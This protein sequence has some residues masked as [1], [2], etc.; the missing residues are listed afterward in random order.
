MRWNREEYLSHMTFQGSPREMFTEIFGLMVGVDK[1][2]K[3]QGATP[4][5]ISLKAFGWDYVPFTGTGVH[6]GARTGMKPRIISDTPEETISIDEMGRTMRLIKSSATIPLPLDHPVKGPED[7][8]RIRHWYEFDEDRIDMEYVRSLKKLQDQ[9]VV[10]LAGIP[11]GF[12]EPRQLL[13]E[14]GLCYAFYDEPEMIHDMLDTMANTCLKCYERVADYVQIDMLGVHEDMAGRSGPLIG[15]NLIEEFISPYYRKVWEPLKAQG[16][17]LFS[18]DSDGNMTA[19]I[20]AFLDAG[21]NCMYP[22]E[23]QAGMDVR[24]L[25]EK[26][27]SRLAF[28]GG[29]NKFA[30][31]GT[32][33][34]IRRELEYKMQGS[35]LG[36]GTV[37]AIDH[38]VPD[39]VPIENYRYY[40]NLGRE[41]LGLPPVSPDEHRV[42]AF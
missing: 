28:K 20:D 37:F 29:L 41:M 34:D 21:I 6:M 36:G 27:G 12:D 23:P 25:R 5:E 2:W 10:I 35:L 33:E 15:S 30:L 24:V 17:K 3:A 16:A 9:G 1:A 22:C 40:V 32:K 14:E 38:R 39:G 8:E 7:W 26:Y 13:G 18:Q 42:M 19:A 11:G 4:D 31:R